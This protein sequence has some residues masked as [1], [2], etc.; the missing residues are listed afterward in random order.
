M[1][2]QS[3]NWSTLVDAVRR[4]WEPAQVDARDPMALWRAAGKVPDPWQLA[5]TTSEAQQT[6]LLCSRQ[7]GKSTAMA[8][9]AYHTAVTVPDSTTLIVSRSLR[10]ANELKRKVD[11]FHYASRGEQADHW[12]RTAKRLTRWQLV[13]RDEI[14]DADAVRNTILS[15][16]LANGSRVL[17]MPCMTDTAVGFTIDL[18]V[19]DEAARIPDHVAAA[20]R[21][22][23]ARARSRGRGRLIAASTPNGKRG[24][25]WEEWE[26]CQ[27]AIAAGR[28]PAWECYNA[29]GGA[30]IGDRAV[31]AEDCSWLT[32]EFLQSELESI[33]RRWFAQEYGCEFVDAVDQV[34]SQADIDRALRVVDDWAPVE[35]EI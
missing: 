35:D 30:I 32:Q 27:T 18:L 22:T 28:K 8:A 17:A 23:L 9:A 12:R 5:V 19:Y 7:R 29:V 24:W 20:M 1:I 33:G 16:E 15:M 2:A 25:F 14:D 13:K 6:L 3:D 21:P 31:V 10:Q 4:W 11:E 34:F 26:R